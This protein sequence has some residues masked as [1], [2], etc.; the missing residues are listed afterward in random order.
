MGAIT[1]TNHGDLKTT[2]KLLKTLSKPWFERRLK[3]YG[4]M[5][6]EALMAATPVDTGKTRDSWRYEIKRNNDKTYSIVWIND[7]LSEGDHGA[8]VV[9]LLYFGHLTRQGGYVEGRDFITP[10]IRPVFD[11]I[12]K[13]AWKEVS[14]K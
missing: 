5:G 13:D 1:I 11:K 12:A 7:N 9:V 3:K 8:P 14:N 10:A 2:D 4:E 6:V